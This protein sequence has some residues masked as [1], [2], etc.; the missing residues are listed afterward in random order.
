LTARHP[1]RQIRDTVLRRLSVI[2]A[3][4]VLAVP[5]VAQSRS[6]VRGLC[7][8]HIA[9]GEYAQADAALSMRR[10]RFDISSIRSM[11]SSGVAFW[12]T[13][14]GTTAWRE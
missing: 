3:C 9:A 5:V 1:P 10:I 4:A 14:A 13:S 8:D 6:G 12:S 2:S 7:G 11:P